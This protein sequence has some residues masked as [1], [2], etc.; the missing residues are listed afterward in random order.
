MS[1]RAAAGSRVKTSKRARAASVRR[2]RSADEMARK[3][4]ERA[5]GFPPVADSAAAEAAA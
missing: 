2:R 5:E 3:R 4:A 1:V